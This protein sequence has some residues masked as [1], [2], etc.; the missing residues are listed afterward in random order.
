MAM[1][2]NGSRKWPTSAWQD[3][4]RKTLLLIDSLPEAPDWSFG[5]G[6]SLSVHLGHRHSYDIDAFVGAS[7]VVRALS[8][9][10]NPATKVLLGGRG[11]DYPGHYLKLHLD[12]G[13]ID[14]LIGTKVSDIPTKEWEFEG[15]MVLIDTPWET[16]AKKLFYR[17][18][19]LKVRDVFDIAAVIG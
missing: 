7:A 15:R 9:N 18:S 16:A 2:G 6:T 19:T 17:P 12:Q 4:L 1:S 3:L 14:F 13:E 11:Y 5:G 10:R 8:P